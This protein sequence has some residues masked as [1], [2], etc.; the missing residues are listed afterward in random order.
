MKQKIALLYL[1]TG[2]G[3]LSGAKSISR[4]LREVYGET[5][6]AILH[7][8]FDGRMWYHRFFFELG[9]QI[10]TNY[11]ELLYVLFYYITSN[12]FF[13]TLIKPFVST[14]IS[15]NLARF[16]RR[17]GIT[18][19]VVLH[20]L[21]VT[22]ARDALDAVDPSIPLIT[23]VMDPFTAHL[24]WFYVKKT[25]LIVFSEKLKKEALEK[26]DF[27]EKQVHLF[28]FMLSPSFA[29]KYSEQE[30]LLARTR[31]GLPLDEKI[32][33]IAGGGEGLKGATRLVSAFLRAGGTE[34][35]VVVCGKNRLLKRS[36]DLLASRTGTNRLVIYGFV[37]FMSDLMNVADCIITKGGPATV[38]EVLAVQKPVILFAYIRPQ[39][40]GNMLH[41][42][43]NDVGWYLTNPR[44]VVSQ[45]RRVLE[46]VDLQHE[47]AE[48]IA[49]LNVHSGTENI[50]KFIHD[51]SN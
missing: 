35:L 7:D 15:N 14:H 38:M 11:L 12:K 40:R 42:V 27:P 5:S 17:E 51:F 36:L 20:S 45:A 48:R 46:D 47:I 33:L 41:V 3:H 2:G 16:I 28:P 23:I 1:K 34:K 25:E 37:D 18:K 8:A 24:G 50:V 22:M 32:L 43:Q 44:D 21:L 6:E 19:V 10:S 49:S 26:Y 29:H 13:V 9:Y 31:L 39:E 30:C 4:V